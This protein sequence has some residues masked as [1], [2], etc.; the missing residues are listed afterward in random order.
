MPHRAL[1]LFP[2]S[3]PDAQCACQVVELVGE[4]AA[5]GRYRGGV[6]QALLAEAEGL[7]GDCVGGEGPAAGGVGDGGASVG[8]DGD[9][10]GPVPLDVLLG[11]VGLFGLPEALGGG[12]EEVVG[13]RVRG[14]HLFP[15]PEFGLGVGQGGAAAGGAFL[16][17]GAGVAGE[18]RVD[19]RL[20]GGAE[21]GEP[22]QDAPAQFGVEFGAAGDGAVGEPGGDGVGV[23]GD[24]DE[25]AYG[26]EAQAGVVT[27]LGAA[28]E[29]A[30]QGGEGGE[31]G[32]PFLRGQVAVGDDGRR[33]GE[34]ALD[35]GEV[36]FAREVGAD[37][38]QIVRG[39]ELAVAYGVP[40]GV[41][42]D[43]AGERVR[44]AGEGGAD[45]FEGFGV[46][47]DLGVGQVAVVDEEQGGA[48][49]DGVRG[50]LRDVE[51]EAFAEGEGAVAGDVV[52]VEAYGD[53]VGAA[54]VVADGEGVA[55]G[56][57]VGEAGVR[58][59]TPVV[60]SQASAQAWTSRSV[61]A[62]R[63]SMK[64]ARV[65]LPKRWRAK[66]VLMPARKSFSPSQATSWRRAEA[67]LA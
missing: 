6:A 30:A 40:Q 67:P 65:A 59:S 12:D 47:A 13:E 53:A 28:D 19:L 43:R 7:G 16:A 25:V 26:D 64:S 37:G 32:G 34:D 61:A 23:G 54:A 50:V 29:V 36:R 56:V 33:E 58:V 52:V 45:G 27:V 62:A 10:V 49:A 63:E 18:F 17:G 31:G 21:Y 35:E 4:F 8:G 48:L 24:G 41:P 14:E 60:R 42:D 39:R 2:G 15:G 3:F 22:G 20:V 9:G 66:W 57:A 38:L 11:E 44:E 46:E 1:R 55:A 5:Q 51:V